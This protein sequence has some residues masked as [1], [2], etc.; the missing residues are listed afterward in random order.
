MFALNRDSKRD[1][2]TSRALLMAI[3]EKQGKTV[4]RTTSNI[5][6]KTTSAPPG[7]VTLI[8]FLS[9]TQDL[10]PRHLLEISYSISERIKD[11][12]EKGYALGAI[13]FETVFVSNQVSFWVQLLRLEVANSRPAG[14]MRPSSS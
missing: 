11:I 2:I 8:E 14:R 9:K 13:N 6:S 1:S 4:E 3:R 10:Q 5:S 12:H 7:Y